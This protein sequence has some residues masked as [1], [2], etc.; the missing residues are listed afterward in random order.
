M[1]YKGVEISEGRCTEFTVAINSTK[2]FFNLYY[3]FKEEPMSSI[4]LLK[5]D[6]MMMKGLVKYKS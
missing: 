2:V 3:L 4:I 6:I 1:G 5:L